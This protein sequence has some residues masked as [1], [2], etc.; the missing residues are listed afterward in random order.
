M[1]ANTR[2]A[3]TPVGVR[4]YIIQV[5]KCLVGLGFGV[6]KLQSDGLAYLQLDDHRADFG[7]FIENISDGSTTR[8]CQSLFID[9]IKQ[10]DKVSWKFSLALLST[11]NTSINGFKLLKFITLIIVCQF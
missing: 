2:E 10:A 11:Y 1:R 7:Q 6:L 8:D 3:R 4:Q 9:C 5:A